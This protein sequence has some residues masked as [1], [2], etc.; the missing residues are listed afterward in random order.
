MAPD[1]DPRNDF[2][3]DVFEEFEF[4][5]DT[6]YGEEQVET[7]E[8]IYRGITGGDEEY[9]T[10][11]SRAAEAV[12][13]IESEKQRK[14]EKRGVWQKGSSISFRDE[15]ENG[16]KSRV[17][18]N[19]SILEEA[20][21]LGSTGNGYSVDDSLSNLK[22]LEPVSVLYFAD[23]TYQNLE[24]VPDDTLEGFT[25]EIQES[26]FYSSLETRSRRGAK[27]R[28]GDFETTGSINL[29]KETNM[30]ARS[31]EMN[32]ITASPEEF[33]IV[34]KLLERKTGK[35]PPEQEA[36]SPLPTAV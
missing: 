11:P 20:G 9:S 10:R 2:E 24:D 13:F 36:E 4:L 5:L 7:M 31:G 27:I 26:D 23:A 19:L 1:Y 17:G 12:G 8:Q 33:K 28:S 16:F 6:E 25:E 3:S 15:H 22:L 29:L 14:E 18:Q 35:Q 30:I 32:Q 34:R 21:L